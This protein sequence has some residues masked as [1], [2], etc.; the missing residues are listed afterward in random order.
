M[1]GRQVMGAPA[2]IER[3]YVYWLDLR[4]SEVTF[5]QVLIPPSHVGA[6]TPPLST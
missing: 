1:L 5:A 4:T 6:Y 3:P 2:P